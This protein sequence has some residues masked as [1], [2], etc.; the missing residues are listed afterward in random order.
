[1][2]VER[3]IQRLPDDIDFRI[4]HTPTKCWIHRA[5]DDDIDGEAMSVDLCTL[6]PRRHVGQ[7]VGGLEIVRSNQTNL[8]ESTLSRKTSSVHRQFSSGKPLVFLGHETPRNEGAGRLSKLSKRDTVALVSTAHSDLDRLE[9]RIIKKVAQA[10]GDFRLIEPNDKIMVAVSGGKDSHVLLHI[11]ERIRQRAPFPFSLL[12]LNIDQGQPGFPKDTL[13]AYFEAAGYEYL[14]VTEDTYSVVRAK[15][16]PG[17]A[18]CSMCSRLR[19]GIL[20]TQATKLGVTKIA[21]GHHRDDLIETLL[22][23]LF[24]AGQIKTMPARLLSDDKRHVVIRPL[25]YCTE[26]EIARL[27]AAKE[28]P[29]VPCSSCSQQE[30]LQRKRVKNLIAQLAQENPHVPDSLAA[31][32][33]NVRLTHLLDKRLLDPQASEVG[34]ND[35]ATPTDDGFLPTSEHVQLPL[36]DR[37]RLAVE[38]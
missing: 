16:P 6:V 21:L 35:D 17:K 13:P 2:V 11:L 38:E 23:N 14:I 10:S 33:K 1:M 9:E 20:Y 19:R 37:T 27:A 22:L 5:L 24:F 32:L 12:A 18:A 7:P 3:S 4:V 31:A 30:N 8:H 15:T 28:F 34:V 25:A 36:Y 29:I 26:S